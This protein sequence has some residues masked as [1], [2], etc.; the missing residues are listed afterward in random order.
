[1]AKI[2][3]QG[4]EWIVVPSIAPKMVPNP[5][6]GEPGQ[7][8]QVPAPGEPPVEF[9]RFPSEAEAVQELKKV[10]FK[11]YFLQVTRAR[12]QG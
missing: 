4:N 11:G 2:I 12:T 6:V 7:P 3:Q 5:R 9:G 10:A 8:P 1:M